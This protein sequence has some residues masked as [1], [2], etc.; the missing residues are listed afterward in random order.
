MLGDFW[1]EFAR[2]FCTLSACEISNTLFFILIFYIRKSICTAEIKYLCL[3]IKKI[4]IN[5]DP[6][7]AHS[8]HSL[9]VFTVASV[10]NRCMCSLN[11]MRCQCSEKQAC[12]LLDMKTNT[13]TIALA[14]RWATGASNFSP[15]TLIHTSDAVKQNKNRGKTKK[16]TF[17]TILLN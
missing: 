10:E 8:L 3:E 15:T 9:R 14:A 6:V 4:R 7:R 16:T 11:T 5:S 1:I 17:W 2:T 13:I 12:Q